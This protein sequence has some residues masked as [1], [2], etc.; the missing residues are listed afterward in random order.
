MYKKIDEVLH[1]Q[2]LL[3]IPE[4]IQIELISQYYN[5][6]LAGYFS[7]NKTKK[8]IGWKYDYPSLKKDIEANVKGCNICLG[9]KAVKH[10]PY[11]DLQSL[12]IS[13]Y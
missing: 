8:L 2:R 1:Y 6:F 11:N 10:K 5:N 12:S 3:F 7:I 13:T 4:I 9:L